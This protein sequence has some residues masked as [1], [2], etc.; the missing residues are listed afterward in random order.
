MNYKLSKIYNS[1]FD[2]PTNQIYSGRI[3][4]FNRT[5]GDLI[6]METYKPKPFNKFV[7]GCYLGNRPKT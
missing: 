4:I 1:P 2:I 6:T 5:S 3:A 7:E